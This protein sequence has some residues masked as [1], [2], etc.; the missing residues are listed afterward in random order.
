[1]QNTGKSCLYVDGHANTA[2]QLQIRDSSSLR[3]GPCCHVRGSHFEFEMTWGMCLAYSGE[4]AD[5]L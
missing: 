2:A 4:D 1:M 3:K 5:P